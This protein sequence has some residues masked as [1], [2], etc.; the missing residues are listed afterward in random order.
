M[1]R[2]KIL[3]FAAAAV[4]AVLSGALAGALTLPRQPVENVF[5]ARTPE[6]VVSPAPSP[7]A[8]PEPSPSLDISGPCDE[9]E[10]ADDPACFAVDDD[11][12]HDD[13][14]DSSGPGGGGNSG[15]G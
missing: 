6:D 5:D 12:D 4:I 13:D 7:S 9:L 14:G 1:R 10:H 11:D 8:S 3:L 15:P 2:T